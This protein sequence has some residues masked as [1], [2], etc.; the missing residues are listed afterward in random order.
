MGAKNLTGLRKER[1]AGK[2]RWIIDFRYTDTDGR[3]QRFRRDASV[4]LR[5]PAYKEA[6]QYMQRAMETGDPEV[7]T[8]PT[9]MT[10]HDFVEERWKN[11]FLP[12]H[13]PATRERYEA[14]LGQGIDDRF[15]PL[16]LDEIGAMEVRPYAVE[17]Q[18][19][20]VQSWPH[21]SLVSAILRA[22]VEA[23]ALKEMPKLPPHGK[24]RR[25]LPDCPDIEEVEATLQV[26]TPLWLKTAIALGVY[27]G[28]R[29]GE[30]RALEVCHIDLKR[31]LLMVK[32]ALSANEVCSPK[33]GRERVVPIG[34]ELRPILVE[35]IKDKLPHA[36]VVLTTRGTTPSRQN[37]LSRLH[38]VQ[39]KHGLQ[40]RTVHQL[41]HAFC[42]WLLQHGADVELVRVIAGHEDI[43]T[44][45][46]YLHARVED[47]RRVMGWATGGK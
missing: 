5:D 12:R 45:S 9:V 20:G 10:F 2:T 16:R 4:Q 1:R 46:Q 24:K 37:L 28:L 6:L 35:A 31:D 43:K 44:T 42:T 3:R 15:G 36:R 41:R 32:Q 26:A 21:T 27:A 13:R 22:A 30:I 23:G 38:R 40:T 29:S 25:K 17:L 18:A 47:A 14:L 19:R 34:P 8:K 39:E 33:S 11:F 7:P